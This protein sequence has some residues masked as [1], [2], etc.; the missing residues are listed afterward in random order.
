MIKIITVPLNIKK[1]KYL[2]ILSNKVINLKMKKEL[3]I[4]IKSSAKSK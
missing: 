1:K 2:L 3:K 4:R